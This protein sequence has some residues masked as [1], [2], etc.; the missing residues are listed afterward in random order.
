V[1]AV[2]TG[3]DPTEEPDMPRTA[4]SFDFRLWTRWVATFVGFPLAG[5]AARAVAGNIDDVQSALVGGLV[6]GAVLGGVQ[7]VALPRAA[8]DAA[9]WV[10]ATAAGMALGL[11]A[12]TAAVGFTT[13]PP[14]LVV[15][16]L[17]TGTGVGLAQ[18]VT[19]RTAPARRLAWALATPAIWGLGWLITSQVIVD[20]DRQHANFGASGALVAS[21]LGGL[22]L[23][24]RPGWITARGSAAGEAARNGEQTTSAC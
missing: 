9:T 3:D 4:R 11:T 21:L 1:Y 20:A 18:A 23:A 22:V 15:M 13:D 24:V 8:A 6:A 14:S 7:A 19:L 16:G 12:G 5:L 17:L 10:A 2:H